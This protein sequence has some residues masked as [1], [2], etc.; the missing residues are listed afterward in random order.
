MGV[1]SPELCQ[2]LDTNPVGV[3]ATMSPGG[4][5][6]QSLVYFVRD[7][8]LDVERVTAATHLAAGAT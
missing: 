6:R 2:L 8:E 7:G 3:L 4:R 5:P 1:L